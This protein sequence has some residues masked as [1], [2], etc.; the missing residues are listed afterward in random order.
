MNDP[1]PMHD[2]YLMDLQFQLESEEPSIFNL[3]PVEIDR[4]NSFVISDMVISDMLDAIFL[5]KAL[6]REN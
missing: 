4:N 3:K 6:S 1:T 5:E 2:P